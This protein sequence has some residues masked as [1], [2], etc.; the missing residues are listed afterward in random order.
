VKRA[1]IVVDLDMARARPAGTPRAITDTAGVRGFSI[2]ATASIGLPASSLE[3]MRFRLP[4]DDA[5]RVIETV[6]TFPGV[7]DARVARVD[8]YPPDDEPPSGV[9]EP[10]NPL[11]PTAHMAAEA[12]D[13]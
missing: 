9:R 3:K 7:V 5:D 8:D 6:L 2:E 4:L 12:D 11:P 10:R 13:E 1:E